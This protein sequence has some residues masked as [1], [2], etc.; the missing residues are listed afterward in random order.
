MKK[1]GCL[2]GI[3]L[4]GLLVFLGV[5]KF[6]EFG[7]EQATII[8]EKKEEQATAK[9]EKAKEE[10]A[11]AAKKEEEQKEASAKKEADNAQ[12][13]KDFEAVSELIM[14]SNEN[15]KDMDIRQEGGAYIVRALVN[16]T[17][18]ANSTESQKKSF[19][20]SIKSAVDPLAPGKIIYDIISDA[21]QDVIASSKF[22]GGWDIKR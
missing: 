7:K 10:K 21:N 19:A 9:E 3:V 17:A 18:W 8:E 11:A 15:V 2:F 4:V 22:L 13:T 6:N 20:Q 1:F 16:E 5:S 14:D 12:L